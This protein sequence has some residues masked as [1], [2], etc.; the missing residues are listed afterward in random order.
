MIWRTLA[1]GERVQAT[2]AAGLW[3]EDIGFEYRWG[4]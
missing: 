1:F 4:E 3:G 2:A